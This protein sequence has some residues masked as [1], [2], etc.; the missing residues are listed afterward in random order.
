M[1]EKFKWLA[2]RDYADFVLE[3]GVEPQ[4]AECYIAFQGAGQ[5]LMTFALFEYDNK[6]PKDDEIFFYCKNLEELLNLNED[7]EVI[8]VNYFFNE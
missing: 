1:L 5:E 2:R 3:N 6:Y 4:F 7:F 8:K